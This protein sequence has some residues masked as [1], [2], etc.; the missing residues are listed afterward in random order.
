MPIFSALGAILGGISLPLLDIIA[1][2]AA[3][4]LAYVYRDEIEGEINE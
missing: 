2:V 1:A 4:A 3:L